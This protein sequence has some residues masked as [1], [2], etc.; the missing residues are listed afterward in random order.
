MFSCVVF[1]CAGFAFVVLLSNKNLDSLKD[2][3]SHQ[4]QQL[5]SSAATVS[6]SNSNTTNL[7]DL[8]N[9]TFNHLQVTLVST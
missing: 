1:L 6:V 5:M 2:N 8:I 3:T 9:L 4:S 7:P